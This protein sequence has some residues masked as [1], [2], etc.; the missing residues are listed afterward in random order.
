MN[1]SWWMAL[2]G[3]LLGMG[4]LAAIASLLN[5]HPPEPWDE[6][7]QPWDEDQDNWR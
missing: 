5:H 7:N 4:L 6:D 2:L 3:V 1:K